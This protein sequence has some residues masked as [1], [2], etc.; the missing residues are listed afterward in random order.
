MLTGNL[1]QAM[2]EI[3]AGS[4]QQVKKDFPIEK[5]AQ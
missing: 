3:H 5:L 1:R 4:L 2:K